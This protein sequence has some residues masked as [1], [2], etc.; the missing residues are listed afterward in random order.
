MVKKK[1]TLDWY[2][3]WCASLILLMGIIS[4]ASG[5][6]NYD[7]FFSIIGCS[8]WLVVSCLW[9]DRALIILNSVAVAILF[10]GIVNKFKEVELL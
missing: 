4:R 10:L 2:I 9:N 3:K 5:L 7:L 8:L 1:K 6:N